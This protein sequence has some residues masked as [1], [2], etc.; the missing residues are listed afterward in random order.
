MR[1]RI[2]SIR[3]GTSEEKKKEEEKEEKKEK[4]EVWQRVK[5]YEP[6]LV[7]PQLG[8]QYETKA[9][10]KRRK[11]REKREEEE[12]REEK[13]VEE[14]EEEREEESEEEKREEES[15]DEEEC[16]ISTAEV[17]KIQRNVSSLRRRN[18]LRG[19]RRISGR[20][21]KLLSNETEDYSDHIRHNFISSRNLISPSCM[22]GRRQFIN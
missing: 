22:R 11:E 2:E 21:N 14:E 8:K 18:S 19:G 4:E 1:K 3:S 7:L 9:V 20:I 16:F 17:M 13:R 10:E 15:G 5:R 12:K 6:H